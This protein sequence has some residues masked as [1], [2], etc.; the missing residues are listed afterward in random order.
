MFAFPLGLLTQVTPEWLRAA[1]CFGSDSK[2]FLNRLA[3]SD[4]SRSIVYL[5]FRRYEEAVTVP[6]LDCTLD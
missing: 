1:F 3:Q 5:V 4:Y 2:L 6:N